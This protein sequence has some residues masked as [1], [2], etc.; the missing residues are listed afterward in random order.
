MYK[1]KF[2]VVVK[3]NGSILRER[4]GGTVH[5][6]F[7]SHYSI[8]LKNKNSCKASVSIE[9]DGKDVLNGHTLILGAN[10]S[11]E[12]KGWMRN[13]SKTNLFKFINKTK[14][15]QDYRGDRI[16][17]GLIRVTYQFE[18]TY[19]PIDW[20]YLNHPVCR[21][22]DSPDIGGVGSTKTTWTYS[23]SSC[24]DTVACCYSA[25]F[26]D[27]KKSSAPR[28]DEGITVK[29]AKVN[30]GYAYGDIG[31]LED[32]TNTIVLHLK[33]I[34]KRKKVV[35]RP[36]TVKTRFVCDTCGKKSRSSAKFCSRCGN[37]LN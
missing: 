21:G 20:V 35:K 16:D 5:L 2:V 15:I 9:V 17:D 29:G 31:T 4:S 33:G 27:V 34:T 3:C 18:K 37:Y 11:D 23:N 26:G 22:Y 14:Q 1:N 7:G 12:I 10:Q 13:M 6:P 19:E 25:S 24:T 8:L 32:T 36:L 30:Q 28:A